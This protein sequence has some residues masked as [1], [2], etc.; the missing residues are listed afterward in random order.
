M[1][2]SSEALGSAPGW[3]KIRIPSRK[4]MIVGIEVIRAMAA[5]SG[6]ASVSILPKTMSVWRPDASSKTGA[7]LRQGPH[8]AAHQSTRTMSLLLMV[9]LKVSLVIS[10]VGMTSPY[11]SSVVGHNGCRPDAI[12]GHPQWY[13]TGETGHW[14][15]FAQTASGRPRPEE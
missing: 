14:V 2:S 5:S 4:A 8:H 12:S 6:W 7:K 15:P 11:P 3:E 9:L 1:S 10:C 13:G